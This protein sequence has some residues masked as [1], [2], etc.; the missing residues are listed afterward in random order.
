MINKP[1]GALEEDKYEIKLMQELEISRVSEEESP[2]KQTS[3]ADKVYQSNQV[4]P[5]TH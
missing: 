3:N 5:K 2:K 4:K 1:Y